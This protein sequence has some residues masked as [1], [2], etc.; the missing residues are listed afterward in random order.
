M[1]QP[2]K[3]D[4]LNI[5]YTGGVPVDFGEDGPPIPITFE[6]DFGSRGFGSP[7]LPASTPAIEIGVPPDILTG[8]FVFE[9]GVPFDLN[10]NL[11]VSG[12]NWI[13]IDYA[14]TATLDFFDLPDGATIESESGHIYRVVPEPMTLSLLGAALVGL[15]VARRRKV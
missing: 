10:G 13:T 14:H 6:Q 11:S 7:P 3:Q 2:D 15:G 4:R 5:F 12:E 9:Y 8:S 1:R